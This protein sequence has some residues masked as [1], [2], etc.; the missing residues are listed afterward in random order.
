M[1]EIV[2]AAFEDQGRWAPTRAQ[3]RP[4]RMRYLARTTMEGG[5]DAVWREEIQVERC[6]VGVEN[7]LLVEAADMSFAILVSR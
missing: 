1:E 5:I 2:D 7:L 4:S 3:A 6:W